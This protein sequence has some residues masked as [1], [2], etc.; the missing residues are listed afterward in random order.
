MRQVGRMTKVAPARRDEDEPVL[1]AAAQL[2]RA[3]GYAATSLREVA[4]AAGMLPGS[5][6]YRYASKESLLVALMERG[7]GRLIEGIR[8]ALDAVRDP[9]DRI[10]IGL[11]THARLV[12]GG[13]G[14]IYVLL[15]DWR[16]LGDT[17][18]VAI[19]REIARYEAFWDGLLYEALGTGRV[20]PGVDPRILR[21]LGFGAMNWL[22]QWYD[23]A[24]CPPPE[25]IADAF[26]AALAFGVLES[27]S[28][29]YDEEQ[30][31]R[32][33]NAATDSLEARPRVRK[34]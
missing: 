25:A 13:D 7:V 18:R 4:R 14:S 10:R 26:F 28:R 19:E 6:H 32:A 30:V 3:K 17:A 33:L 23:A 5:L 11:R 29:P 22:P 16:A 1:T 8:A 9:V 24:S 31:F 34:G 27:T 20:R 21:S 12:C 2:F 15:Y